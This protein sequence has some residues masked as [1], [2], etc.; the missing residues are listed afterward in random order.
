MSLGFGFRTRPATAIAT[1]DP[2]HSS[3]GGE[4]FYSSVANARSQTIA[5]SLVV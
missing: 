5:A 2:R 3:I 4:S 1:F